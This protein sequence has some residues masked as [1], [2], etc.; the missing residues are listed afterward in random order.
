M[1]TVWTLIIY[2]F[3]NFYLSMQSILK[4]VKNSIDIMQQNI[5][6]FAVKNTQC[7]RLQF[8]PTV[9]AILFHFLFQVKIAT[10]STIK[11][12]CNGE[13]CYIDYTK[14]TH[15]KILNREQKGGCYTEENR[16]RSISTDFGKSFTFL[17]TTEYSN[18]VGHR[19]SVFRRTVYGKVS[20]LRTLILL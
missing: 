16:Y 8:Q 18:I 6:I 11:H 17:R 20:I 5:S 19:K 4:H 3:L 9:S 15:F 13:K 12:K 2:I 14:I 7:K 1:A 10:V